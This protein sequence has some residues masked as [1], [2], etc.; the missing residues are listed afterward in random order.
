MN[1]ELE[2]SMYT[3]RDRFSYNHEQVDSIGECDNCK[4]DIFSYDECLDLT[5]Y[6]FCCND[7]MN[8]YFDRIEKLDIDK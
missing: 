7:C 3:G 1:Y 2:N 4:D 5:Y 6:I 8:E